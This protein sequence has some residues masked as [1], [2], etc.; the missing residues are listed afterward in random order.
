MLNIIKKNAK[1]DKDI[2]KKIYKQYFT[3]KR[4]V[5]FMIDMVLKIDPEICKNPVSLIDPACGEGVFIQSA[6]KRNLTLP[7]LCRGYDRDTNLINKW[8][9]SYLSDNNSILKITDSL[10][11]EDD[12]KYKLAMGNPPFGIISIDEDKLDKYHSFELFE[13]NTKNKP[14]TQ[15][16]FPIEVFFLER[17]LD[18]LEPGGIAAIVLP[19]GI[20]A[21]FKMEYIRKWLVSKYDVKAIVSIKKKVFTSEGAAAN[22]S[23]IFIKNTP[24]PS[25]KSEI[26]LSSITDVDLESSGRDHLDELLE[27]Y[28][29]KS[30]IIKADFSAYLIPLENLGT[31]RWEAEF[32]H[33]R[34]EK[35]YKDLSNGNFDLIPLSDLIT[36]DNIITGYK[37]PQEK[38]ITENQIPFVTSKHIFPWGIDM[39]QSPSYIDSESKPDS[40]RSRLLLKDVLLVRS[41]EGCIGRSAVVNSDWTGAN[42][43]SE[44]YIIRVDDNIINPYYLSLFLNSFKT[45]YSSGRK[46]TGHKVHF[47]ISRFANGV[48]TPNL[49]KDE[50]LLIKVPHIS[51]N[52]QKEIEEKFLIIE[53]MYREIRDRNIKIANFENE[54]KKFEKNNHYTSL[55]NNLII[56][57]QKLT[58]DMEKYLVN[59]GELKY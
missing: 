35:Y 51:I 16:S 1:S 44:I 52:K 5:D 47:Q 38:P 8:K 59:R 55:T 17:F 48:G 53:E 32:H 27:V 43:R 54:I 58:G 39:S 22:T 31:F 40:P 24:N 4:I 7:E 42:I 30:S 56:A 41:G 11:H 20:F 15:K 2:R 6:I 46:N 3:P 9:E 57:T 10:F 14:S 26:F 23:L 28:D 13:I 37:G 50:I 45:V 21:N 18:F 34:Y 29:K 25:P 33:P 36:K 19:Q 49:N 12:T